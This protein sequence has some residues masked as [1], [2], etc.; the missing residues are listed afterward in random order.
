[1]VTYLHLIIVL[2]QHDEIRYVD[3][4]LDPLCGGIAN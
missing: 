4:A 2:V 3:A 1:M